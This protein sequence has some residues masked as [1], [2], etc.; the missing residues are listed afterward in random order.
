MIRWP[1]VAMAVVV[2]ASGVARAEPPGILSAVLPQE[3]T[4]EVVHVDRL[5]TFMDNWEVCTSGE[6]ADPKRCPRFEWEVQVWPEQ[7]AR[8]VARDI[9]RAWKRFQERTY[10]RAHVAVNNWAE[11]LIE[12][13]LGVIQGNGFQDL[14]LLP[15]TVSVRAEDVPSGLSLPSGLAFQQT[16]P[17]LTLETDDY[18]RAGTLPG[19]PGVPNDDFCDGMGWDLATMYV[20]GYRLLF[21]GITIFATPDWPKPLNWSL[22]LDSYT[23]Q[24]YQNALQHAYST[25]LPQYWQDI[26]RALT[27]IPLALHWQG[28]NPAQNSGVV[29]QPVMKLTPD[30]EYQRAVS[31]RTRVVQQAT[32]QDPRAALYYGQPATSFPALPME[33][34]TE[35]P[36]IER[37]EHYKRWLQAG[38][39]GGA[40]SEPEA[41]GYATF[42]Q[43]WNQLDVVVDRPVIYFASAQQTSCTI[44]FFTVNC[45]E[46][47]VPVA[48]PRGVITHT[49]QRVHW[50]FVTVPEGYRIP[51]TSGVPQGS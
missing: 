21:H 5:R 16:N 50:D 42:F 8:E 44:G 6:N 45:V 7:Q 25:Y 39:V 2:A 43:A 26:A 40:P 28:L 14:E 1:V 51:R 29:L 19:R 13:G 34:G 37:L 47:T 33:G 23:Q 12:C 31:E 46:E 32:R 18:W 30:A 24:V 49:T 22:G 20:P 3:G 27:R 38:L 4:V 36:G 17:R 48:I 35:P 41:G 9:R 11:Y 15:A 10:W